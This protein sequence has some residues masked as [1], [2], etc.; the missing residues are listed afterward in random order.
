METINKLKHLIY[1]VVILIGILAYWQVNR[2]NRYEYVV[3]DSAQYAI[4]KNTHLVYRLVRNHGENDLGDWEKY[5]SRN[6]TKDSDSEYAYYEAL[7]KLGNEKGT[8][9]WELITTEKF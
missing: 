9:H 3:R 8:W 7:R 4:D 6:D 2:Y 1:A 5:T